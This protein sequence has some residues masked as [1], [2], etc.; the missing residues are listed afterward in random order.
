MAVKIC[1]G[2]LADAT[3]AG[4]PVHATAEGTPTITENRAQRHKGAASYSVQND[5]E[6]P[7]D[8]RVKGRVR[9]ALDRLLAAG[10]MGCTPITEPA[11][12][13]SAYVFELRSLGVHIETIH[14]KHAGDFPG[15]HARYV[16]RAKV[17]EGGAA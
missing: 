10:R 15:T 12:R 9:W 3:G 11:P 5:R 16:L 8:I 17:R 4:K 13:W 6:L 14:E 1:P 7:F 2:A